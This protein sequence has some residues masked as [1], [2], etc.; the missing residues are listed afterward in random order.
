M[1]I[2]EAAGHSGLPPKTIRYYEEIGLVHPLRNSNGYRSFQDQD[3]HN[4]IFL[5]RARALGFSIEDCRT[6]LDLNEDSTRESTKVKA[7]A[8][9]HLTMIEEKIA[10]LQS[11][12][13]ILADLVEAC[14]GNDHAEC[15]ILD[16]LS[17]NK[18]VRSK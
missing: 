17:D 14:K 10:H 12:H 6:L 13:A 8:K 1:N 15:P 7:V 2:G 18:S 4:L 3:L 9:E 16:E 5:K 11:M